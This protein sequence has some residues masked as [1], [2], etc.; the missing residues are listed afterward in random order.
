[1]TLENVCYASEYFAKKDKHILS[2][3][4]NSMLITPAEKAINKVIEKV[5][6]RQ[7]EY[8]KCHEARQRLKHLNK[9]L[10][11]IV[12]LVHVKRL[13]NKEIATKLNISI[14]TIRKRY[15]RAKIIVLGKENINRRKA[16][17]EIK[18]DYEE[19]QQS[20]IDMQEDI[21]I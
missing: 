10:K 7:R 6:A 14:Q 19:L 21:N 5:M 8:I 15:E 3:A 12:Y 20:R 2:Y 16:L 17:K 1:M 11:I 18:T 9:K 13:K 4:I